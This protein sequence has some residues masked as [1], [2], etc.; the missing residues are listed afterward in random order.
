MSVLQGKKIV[1]G[2]TGGIA[3]YKSAEL[4]R[5]LKKKGALVKV[6]MTHAATQFVT[7]LTFQALSGEAVGLQLLDT[8]AENAMGHIE[9]ARWA[10]LVLV[11]PASANF[12]ARLANGMASDLLSTLCLA[13]QAPI[14]VA[15]AMNQQMWANRATQ[16]NMERIR[17][18]GIGVLGP[19][20]GEQACGEIGYGR[21]LEPVE[22]VEW[23]AYLVTPKRLAEI[24]TVVTAGPTWE[25]IDPVRFIGNRSSGKMGFA[26]ASAAAKAGANVTLIAGP[27]SLVTPINIERI[28]VRSAAEMYRAVC[29]Q[30]DHCQLFI[31]AAAVAD[32]RPMHR[33]AN[34]IKKGSAVVQIELEPTDD[35]VAAVAAAPNRPFTVGFAAE[36]EQL[37]R[38]ARDKLTRKNLDM[39][40]ANWVGA[41]KLGFESD[42]NALNVF[43]PDGEQALPKQSK[44]QLAEGLI[45]LIADQYWKKTP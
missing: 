30:L 19:A 14:A 44:K 37:E 17:Q 40:A 13:T 26:V 16:S 7:P 11:A 31:A 38:Y 27:T 32:Y 23:L 15:P 20:A 35:I 42:D 36:T 34:K 4:V 8:E 33:V 39:I 3:A 43:W 41:D 1:I 12:L 24:H 6:V 45:E 22:L 9:W 21:M 18:Y 25:A 5:L 2:V 10:D 28:D 29:D